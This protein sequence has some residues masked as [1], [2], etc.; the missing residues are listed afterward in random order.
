MPISARSCLLLR[1]PVDYSLFS[2]STTADLGLVKIDQ[3]R[4]GSLIF[5][6]LI[7]RRHGVWVYYAFPC[8]GTNSGT[9]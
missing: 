5:A 9:H 2:I 8:T 7:L 3:S 4:S 1:P 6:T